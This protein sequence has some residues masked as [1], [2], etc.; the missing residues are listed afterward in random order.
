MKIFLTASTTIL[1]VTATVAGD[2]LCQLHI[3]NPTTSPSGASRSVETGQ[4]EMLNSLS[5]PRRE[6]TT[7]FS[8]FSPGGG[9]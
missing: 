1:K 4:A 6:R 9:S 5:L 7:S 3:T 8:A 2:A